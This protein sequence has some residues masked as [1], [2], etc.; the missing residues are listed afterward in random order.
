MCVYYQEIIGLEV[1][2]SPDAQIFI[3]SARI[4]QGI[5]IM[6][7]YTGNYSPSH[8]CKKS[9]HMSKQIREPKYKR[10]S[11]PITGLYSQLKKKKKKTYSP[12]K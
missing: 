3:Q 10:R 8:S 7:I 12:P 1:K 11:R 6:I 2:L 9:Y 4:N 5:Q